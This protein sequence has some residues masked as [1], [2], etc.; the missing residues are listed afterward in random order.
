MA[1]PFLNSIGGETRKDDKVGGKENGVGSGVEVQ[2]EGKQYVF[3]SLWSHTFIVFFRKLFVTSFLPFTLFIPCYQSFNA[4]LPADLNLEGLSQSG[5][6]LVEKKKTRSSESRLWRWQTNLKVHSWM[7][8]TATFD[9]NL[10]V[11]RLGGGGHRNLSRRNRE[12]A[13]WPL[14]RGLQV[15]FPARLRMLMW[16]AGEVTTCLLTYIGCFLKGEGD[17]LGVRD[18]HW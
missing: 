1:W 2:A 6:C 15:T 11:G 12:N 16:R 18:E 3:I 9:S 8:H 4:F 5:F 14:L 7:D 13:R 17:S 10:V